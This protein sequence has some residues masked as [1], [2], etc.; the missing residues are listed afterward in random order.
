VATA[1]VFAIGEQQT[2]GFWG[3]LYQLG[4][5]VWTP[6]GPN[7]FP[8][9]NS[10]WASA[11]GMKTR[12]DLAVFFARRYAPHFEPRALLENFAGEAAS[13]E[14]RRA[15]AGAESREQGLAIA[16]MSPEFQRR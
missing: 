13:T 10:H 14:T 9:T 7:G 2:R 12:L 16:L 11:K 4:Q 5:P 1:R 6:P 3:M 8:D 15:I